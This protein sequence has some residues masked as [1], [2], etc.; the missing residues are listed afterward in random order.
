MPGQFHFNPETGRTGKCEA[1]IKCRFGQSA[2]QHGTTRDEARANYEK[3]MEDKLFSNT[4]LNTR[5]SSLSSQ[6]RKKL[7]ALFVEDHVG[8]DAW[9]SKEAQAAFLRSELEAMGVDSSEFSAQEL[10]RRF[11]YLVSAD[12]T[13]LERVFKS[14]AHADRAQAKPEETFDS[15]KLI[16]RNHLSEIALA[17]IRAGGRKDDALLVRAAEIFELQ[18]SSFYP[19]E[20]PVLS[21]PYSEEDLDYQRADFENRYGYIHNYL[22]DFDMHL[23]A[24]AEREN[25]GEIRLAN[26]IPVSTALVKKALEE[27]GI[28]LRKQQEYPHAP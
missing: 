18:K 10:S 11:L 23:L 27:E 9:R 1:V 16:N 24:K 21:Y 20:S 19:V 3:V 22:K 13:R 25:N 7:K 17:K 26:N 2:D 8:N 4:R 28:T 6:E 14:Q 5:G 15:S 12:G